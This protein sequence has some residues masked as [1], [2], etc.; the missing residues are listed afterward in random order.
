M[1]RRLCCS[2]GPNSLDSTSR[3]RNS[4]SSLSKMT[5]TATNRSTRSF[6]GCTT[7]RRASIYGS[8]RWS[9]IR[10]SDSMR[11]RKARLED[12]TSCEWAH[13]SDT[14]GRQKSSRRQ[15]GSAREAESSRSSSEFRRNISRVVR[16]TCS[17]S[18]G[19]LRSRRGQTSRP[20][21]TPKKEKG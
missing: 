21:E 12:K 6:S 3:S 8:A 7:R 16:V 17:G 18:G 1:T 20:P 2:S 4:P 14:A 5:I 11:R 19:I 13:D 9:T 15:R 10:S